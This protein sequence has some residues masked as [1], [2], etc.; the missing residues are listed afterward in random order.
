MRSFVL[1]TQSFPMVFLSPP[2]SN[3]LP[4]CTFQARTNPPLTRALA[5]NIGHV[6]QLRIRLEWSDQDSAGMSVWKANVTPWWHDTAEQPPV[7]LRACTNEW[8]S[9]SPDCSAEIAPWT[10]DTFWTWKDGTWLWPHLFRRLPSLSSD[11]LSW[12]LAKPM[13]S[14]SLV[15]KRHRLAARAP[16]RPLFASTSPPQ[17][18]Y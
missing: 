3:G 15:Y 13:G 12:S 4:L 5:S 11:H 16:F 7:A 8:H 10:H 9:L 2:N 18:R 6:M 1:C 17:H 14:N